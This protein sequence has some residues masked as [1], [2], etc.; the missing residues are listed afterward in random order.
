MLF[1]PPVMMK[2]LGMMGYVLSLMVI[3]TIIVN[4]TL[5]PL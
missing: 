3:L 1:E 4:G 2:L 5:P